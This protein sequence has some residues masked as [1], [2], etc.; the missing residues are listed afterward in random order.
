MTDHKPLT[1]NSALLGLSNELAAQ[2]LLEEGSNDLG[3]SQRRTL[4]AVMRDVLFEPMFLL[5]LAAGAIY[6]LTGDRNE[7]MVLLGFVLVIMGMTVFQER[8]TDNAL[9]ALRDLSSP[10][11][12]VIRSSVEQRIAGH[13][14][15]RDDVLILAEG[16]RVPADG[17]LLQAH[18]LSLDESMLTGES[19]PVAKTAEQSVFAGTL[20]VSGQGVVSVTLTGRHTQM[21]KIGQS[22]DEI[23]P[24]ASPLREQMSS[25]TKRLA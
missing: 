7:A 16:D 17:T 3:L 6:L 18:E 25:L 15:V 4:L 5:L 2:R 14:V 21:G 1:A 8:R 12:L 11:A 22:L 9:A 10:R 19:E 20:V 23:E 13:E 24:Q